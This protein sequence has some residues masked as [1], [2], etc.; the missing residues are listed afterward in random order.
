MAF[1]L[2]NCTFILK[3]KKIVQNSIFSF[4]DKSKIYYVH[5]EVK[6][7]N[8]RYRVICCERKEKT[9]SFMFGICSRC[10]RMYL[11]VINKWIKNNYGKENL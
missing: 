5:K 8:D 7:D 6:M 2:K 10:R 1:Y 3:L 11:A 9:D 4:D